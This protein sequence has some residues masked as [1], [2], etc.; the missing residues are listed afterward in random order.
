MVDLTPSSLCLTPKACAGVCSTVAVASDLVRKSEL[1]ELD[2][3]VV[4]QAMMDVHVYKSRRQAVEVFG[5]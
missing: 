2:C 1:A 5:N 3:N 4:S